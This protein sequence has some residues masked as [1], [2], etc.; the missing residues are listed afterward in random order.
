MKTT[1]LIEFSKKLMLLKMPVN[2]A[3]DL[4]ELAGFN[5]VDRKDML[6]QTSIRDTETIGFCYGNQ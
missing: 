5:V 3:L 2:D 4:L 1:K 6:R